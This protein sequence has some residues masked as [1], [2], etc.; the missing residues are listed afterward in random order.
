[1]DRIAYD[2]GE[3]VLSFGE[4]TDLPSHDAETGFRL[5][6]KWRSLSG[7][8]IVPGSNWVDAVVD[9]SETVAI[10]SDGTLWVSEKPR[11]PWDS[12]KSWLRAK[13]EGLL[14]R[15]GDETNWQ[16]AAR[17]L[18]S[19]LILLK[20]DG[21]LWRWGWGGTNTYTPRTW[22]GLR[23]FYPQRLGADS[24]WTKIISA[25]SSTYAW[26]RDGRAWVLNPYGRIPQIRKLEVFQGLNRLPSLDNTKWRSLGQ[27]WLRWPWYFGVREDGTLWTWSIFARAGPA[28][29]QSL[30][31][32]MVRLGKDADWVAVGGGYQMP[33]ALKADGSLW[34]WVFD[35]GHE[36]DAE[37]AAKSPVRLG[38][39]SDWVA[40]GH[41]W[42]GVV[43]LSADG[44]LWYW[45][46]PL[47]RYESD[48]PMM[49][50]SRK[51]AFIE[52]IFAAQK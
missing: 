10:R 18:L 39:H 36:K 26:K 16:S 49:A 20:Q 17:G 30:S 6:V 21:T 51:P 37:L 25:G 19:S 52:N 14:V 41:V 46:N 28:S 33:T 2:P 29:G 7:N 3:V 44:S 23:G 24:D 34:S 38:K 45:R 42:G 32:R 47:A 1:V 12:R 48:Q 15:F 4:R 27:F 9:S 50:A 22:P 43:S 5:G 40:L 13:E 31:V 8:Q 35:Y 11:Q